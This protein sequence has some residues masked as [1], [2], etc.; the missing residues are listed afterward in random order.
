MTRLCITL[1][2]IWCVTAAPRHTQLL[3]QSPKRHAS[4]LSSLQIL[5]NLSGMAKSGIR[6]SPVRAAARVIVQRARNQ[7]CGAEQARGR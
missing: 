3:Q 1:Q 5:S 2:K 4:S 6:A 7:R